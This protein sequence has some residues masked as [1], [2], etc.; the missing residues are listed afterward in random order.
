MPIGPGATRFTRIWRPTS[1]AAHDR[2]NDRSAAL[3][4]AYT[5]NDALPFTSM[6]EPVMMTEAPALSRGRAF[7][8]VKIVP[9]TFVLNVLA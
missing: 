5:L 4:A 2:A 9:P 8:T 7:C 3:V 1:S 6:S